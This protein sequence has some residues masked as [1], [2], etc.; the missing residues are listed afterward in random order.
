[1]FPSVS[2]EKRKGHLAPGDIIVFYTDGI[3]ESRNK[4]NEEFGEKGLRDFIKSQRKQEPSEIID[5]LL[6]RLNEFIGGADRMDDMT[7]VIVKKV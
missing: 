1:M 7:A 6:K 5:R 4:K 2:Y 3:T